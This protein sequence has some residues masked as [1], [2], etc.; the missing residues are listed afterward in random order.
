MQILFFLQETHL[1]IAHETSWRHEWGAE[2]ISAPGTSN[3][4]GAVL[5]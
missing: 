1:T 5:F 2:I 4:R 3:A